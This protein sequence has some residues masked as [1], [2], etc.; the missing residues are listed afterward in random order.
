MKVNESDDNK[1]ND[2]SD[3][4]DDD[5]DDDPN[6]DDM[7]DEMDPDEIAAQG[8]P[9]TPHDDDNESV[10]SIRD[11]DEDAEPEEE[12][13]TNPTT[14]EE[15]TIPENAQITRSGR[16]SKPPSILNLH[17]SHLQAEAHQEVEYSLETARVIAM[18]MCHVNTKIGTLNDIKTPQGAISIVGN[19]LTQNDAG[20]RMQHHWQIPKSWKQVC[21]IQQWTDHQ[22]NQ[23][24]EKQA[25]W[26]NIWPR[27]A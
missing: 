26:P 1:S 25:E 12:E 5:D 22:V 10:E 24:G 9:T 6:D 21:N 4:D 7:F 14:A 27:I 2:S 13:N 18:T 3:D 15:Q 8:E 16:I 20:A 23:L 11:H 19:K 17:Q